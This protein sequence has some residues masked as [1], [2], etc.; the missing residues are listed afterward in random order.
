MQPLASLNCCGRCWPDAIFET[1][2]KPSE[3]AWSKFLCT[4][5]LTLPNQWDPNGPMRCAGCWRPRAPE[6]ASC[7]RVDWTGA[8]RQSRLENLLSFFIHSHSAAASSVHLDDETK[9]MCKAKMMCST[10]WGRQWFSGCSPREQSQL[11]C[12]PLKRQLFQT[13]LPKTLWNWVLLFLPNLG[14]F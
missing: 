7:E 5:S 4:G 6:Q 1:R 3:F 13:Y 12:V 11:P 2:G 8:Y 14:E 9:E 10:P